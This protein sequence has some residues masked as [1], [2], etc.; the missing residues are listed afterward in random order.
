MLIDINLL[1]KKERKSSGIIFTSL[2]FAALFLAVGGFLYWQGATLKNEI[3]VVENRIDTTKK[4][5]ALEERKANEVVS[6]DSAF[7]L[8]Q[9]IEWAEQYTIPSVPVMKEF[10]KMLPERGYILTYA[11]QETGQLALTVQFDSSREAAYFLNRL[12]KSNWVK[13]AD[14]SSLSAAGNGEE[15]IADATGAVK[16]ASSLNKKEYLPRYTG[17]FQITLNKD[18][19]KTAIQEEGEDGS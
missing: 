8:S 6:A 18:V 4:I 19:I 14:L 13:D 7:K 5:A 11:Y 12:N 10:T 3:A 16:A 2:A 15:Q 1:P 9:G 17:Q